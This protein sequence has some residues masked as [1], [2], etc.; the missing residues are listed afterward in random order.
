MLFGRHRT[1]R[2]TQAGPSGSALPDAEG[3]SATASGTSGA[4]ADL[5]QQLGQ[6]P[7][8]TGQT[9]TDEVLTE[10]QSNVCAASTKRNSWAGCVHVS[11]LWAFAASSEAKLKP[12]SQAKKRRHGSLPGQQPG[13]QQF[14]QLGRAG[15]A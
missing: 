10:D 11:P 3:G 8:L 15:H 5:V 4:C 1:I 9:P 7:V 12:A 6:A 14:L 13:I 2:A